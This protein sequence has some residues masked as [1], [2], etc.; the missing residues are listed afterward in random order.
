MLLSSCAANIIP[1]PAVTPTP[2]PTPVIPNDSII[3]LTDYAELFEYDDKAAQ[4]VRY[5]T[6][7]KLHSGRYY[8]ENG[9]CI[10]YTSADVGK[11]NYFYVHTHCGVA[12]S[13]IGANLFYI[14][15][16]ANYNDDALFETDVSIYDLASVYNVNRSDF[17]P[18]IKRPNSRD[19]SDTDNYWKAYNEYK[20]ALSSDV[21][22]VMSFY[23]HIFDLAKAEFNWDEEFDDVVPLTEHEIQEMYYGAYDSLNCFKLTLTVEEIYALV[24]KEVFVGLSQSINASYADTVDPNLQM[25]I[26]LEGKTG[27]TKYD[28]FVYLDI[29]HKDKPLD[30]ILSD[31][32]IGKN[33]WSKSYYEMPYYASMKVEGDIPQATDKGSF[34]ATLTKEQIYALA[35]DEAVGVIRPNMADNSLYNNGDYA[36]ILDSKMPSYLSE[37]FYDMMPSDYGMGIHFK[38]DAPPNYPTKK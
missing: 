26:D 35:K 28:V 2:T 13:S 33:D 17:S 29:A 10:Y 22:G 32:G 25:L 11:T 8:V 21:K 5:E 16:N 19:Y 38:G 4:K 37:S 34:M 20:R 18:D 3:S 1:I 23:K 7:L 12:H 31:A 9:K 15:E 14:L 6:L 27:I 24:Q 30:T 36:Y